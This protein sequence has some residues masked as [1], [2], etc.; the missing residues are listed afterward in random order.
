MNGKEII[1]GKRKLRFSPE[2]D[3]PPNKKHDSPRSFSGDEAYNSSPFHCRGDETEGSLC[4]DMLDI[5]E[6]EPQE[7][8]QEEP[9]E[10]C[11][12]SL[13]DL[14]KYLVAAMEP[15]GVIDHLHHSELFSD[16]FLEECKET[17]NRKRRND[18]LIKEIYKIAINKDSDVL[19]QFAS[20]LNKTDQSFIV[21]HLKQ[22]SGVP[23]KVKYRR[24]SLMGFIS[25]MK[26]R[27]VENIEPKD[28]IDDLLASRTISFNDHED[29][30]RLD[31]RRQRVAVIME[32]VEQRNSNSLEIIKAIINAYPKI[33]EE[34]ERTTKY[35]SSDDTATDQSKG[36]TAVGIRLLLKCGT[37]LHGRRDQLRRI[38][39]RAVERFSSSN[40]ENNEMI[41]EL[42]E[43]CR[44]MFEGLKISSVVIQL[45]TRAGDSLDKILK[46]IQSGK[47]VDWLLSILDEDDKRMLSQIGVTT[48]QVSVSVDEEGNLRCLN[49]VQDCICL[50]DK[51]SI[52]KNKET[53]AGGLTDTESLIH[54][55]KS[56][57][58]P[59]SQLKKLRLVKNKSKRNTIILDFFAREDT[60]RLCF[61]LLEEH[62]KSRDPSY[63]ESLFTND[64]NE[65]VEIS[66]SDIKQY[67]E[68]LKDELEV[69]MFLPIIRSWKNEK[70]IRLLAKL[71]RCSCR[72]SRMTEFMRF[73]LFEKDLAWFWEQV[74]EK[75]KYIWETITSTKRTIPPP[76]TDVLAAKLMNDTIVDEVD[77]FRLKRFMKEATVY[78]LAFN[79]FETILSRKSQAQYMMNRISE[80]TIDDF[81]VALRRCGYERIYR[82]IKAGSLAK[83]YVCPRIHNANSRKKL[84][85]KDQFDIAAKLSEYENS[86]KWKDSVSTNLVEGEP[87]LHYSISYLNPHV[88]GE[89][90]MS[91]KSGFRSPASIGSARDSE[92]G[93]FSGSDGQACEI[94][95]PHDFDDE[96]ISSCSPRA[97]QELD[98][99]SEQKTEE[100]ERK[101]SRF[102]KMER[103]LRLIDSDMSASRGLLQR[104]LS[105]LTTRPTSNNCPHVEAMEENLSDDTSETLSSQSNLKT[106]DKDRISLRR[107]GL[108]RIHS[109]LV[110]VPNK[111]GH[112]V[113]HSAKI[114]RWRLRYLDEDE[115]TKQPM[116][117]STQLLACKDSEQEIKHSLKKSDTRKQNSLVLKEEKITEDYISP[118]RKNG[119]EGVISSLGR[120]SRK[121]KSTVTEV[122]QAW[123]EAY[124]TK[125]PTFDGTKQPVRSSMQIIDCEDSE[126]EIK[127]SLKNSDTRKQNSLVLK[128]GTRQPVRSSKQILACEDSEEEIKRTLKE[129]DTR[130]QNSLV[131]KEGTKQPVLSSKQLLACGNS[132][133]EIKRSL[134]KLD[135]RKQNSLVL[136]K[137]TKQPVRAS[138]QLIACEDSE[139]E[140]KRIVKKSDKR[141]QNSVV[142]KKGTKQPVCSSKQHLACKNSEEEIKRSLKKSD[143]RKQNS[144]VLK[145]GTKQ[146]VCSSKQHLA[147]EDSE[148]EIKRSLKKS[149][150]RK[151]NSL[152]LKEGTK[153]PV[154]SSKQLLACEDSEEEMKRIVKKSDTRKQNSLVLKEGTKQPVRSSKQLLA[155]EDSEKEMKRILK[156]SDIRKQNS[157]VLKEGTKQPVR[158]STQL[159]AC[160]DS[161]EEIKRTLKKSD[162]RKQHSL[163][164][165]EGTKRPVRSSM[166]LLACEDSGQE[167]MRSLKKSDTR[168]QDSLVLKEGALES[169]APVLEPRKSNAVYK[170]SLSGTLKSGKHMKNIPHFV[171]SGSEIA[172]AEYFDTLCSTKTVHEE[173][174][175][176]S[177]PNDR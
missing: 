124:E 71:S 27:L 11:T 109:E 139:E 172:L 47:A 82:Q 165:K 123:S 135:K 103:M 22:P 133:E 120:T 68:F 110:E 55:M 63:F 37:G 17:P 116:R 134:K 115:A 57:G 45:L 111:D 130:K 5:N 54:Q 1:V 119:D 58:I 4:E 167:T 66:T 2:H 73:L 136:K 101:S 69:Q 121:G 168:K 113:E 177:P 6:E 140:M 32:K 31:L 171:K 164:L 76:K 128:E 10:I 64:I 36:G 52:L 138:K 169:D 154:R 151:Q 158:S 12:E 41:D 74:R 33:F 29:I 102:A 61:C 92:S 126:Q 8:P 129:S 7:D 16:N 20:A 99:V 81:M 108:R 166:Q 156:K 161:E 50:L 142:L 159:F 97:S 155:C 78:A 141:K 65:D 19:Q 21:N 14:Y 148:E 107:S 75:Q 137:G 118:G 112:V 28:F 175:V 83:T 144:L 157:L 62:I 3:Q 147:C 43:E 145:E 88:L 146:P 35:G 143:T 176:A 15:L 25:H 152:V 132:K 127:R 79:E 96:G 70:S 114:P 89:F 67:E 80:D 106:G 94:A 91:P 9:Q 49:P 86:D 46:K 93:I 60:P 87:S 125:T 84:I 30:I 95:N 90:A 105:I 24:S 42:V 174:S 122:K 173:R 53:L 160:E 13:Q 104:S 170:R 39:K 153:Q 26:D 38:E 163:V 150:T 100:I 40:A 98:H 48:L 77:P 149:D 117:S 85:Y 51:Q 59:I 56:F 44:C 34:F 162:T 131:L 72:S 18:L 23:G